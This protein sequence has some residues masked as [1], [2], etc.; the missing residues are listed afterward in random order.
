MPRNTTKTTAVKTDATENVASVDKTVVVDKKEKKTDTVKKIDVDSLKDT[1]EI[2]VVSLISNVSY[3]DSATGD[4]YE[5]EDAGHTEYMS[6]ATIKNLW[7]SSK[8]YFKSLWLKPVDERVVKKFGLDK[9]YKSYDLVLDVD[10]YTK[11]NVE[12]ICNVI[13]SSPKDVKD[14]LIKKVFEIVISGKVTDI[15]IIKTLERNLKIDLVSF[16]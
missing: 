2:E 5:W 6:F 11:N 3:K 9:V 15:F 7:R 1:D 8:T 14:T 4:F 13:L 12:N 16:L 10:N